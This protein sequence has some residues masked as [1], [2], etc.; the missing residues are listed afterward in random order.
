MPLPSPRKLRPL[1]EAFEEAR[2]RAALVGLF[3]AGALLWCAMAL[4][5]TG[6]PPGREG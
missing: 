2:Y 4:G 3:V 1:G 6:A 5:L